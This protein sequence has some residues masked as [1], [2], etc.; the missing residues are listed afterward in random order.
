MAN[1]IQLVEQHFEHT[2]FVG[3]PGYQVDDAH[4][5]LLLVAMDATH[6][7]LKAGRVPRDVVVDHQ[8]AELQIDALAS[9]VGG[10][11]EAGAVGSAKAGH[12][13]F[14]FRP[15]HAAVD[16]GHLIGVAET[17]NAADKEIHGVSVFGEDQPLLSFGAG[18]EGA[19]TVL[20]VL[21]VFQHFAQ[22]LELGF[23]P[24]INQASGTVAQTLQDV[25]FALQF[26][27]GDG[28]DCAKH[29]FLVVL[30]AP[31]RI[32][33]STVQI[34]VVCAMLAVEA[35]LVIQHRPRVQGAGLQFF[36]MPFQLA[37]A[38]LK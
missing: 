10:D 9:G 19:V 33:I 36:D 30:G 35:P 2:A 1:G 37:D 38:P 12:L 7:L 31:L 6:P 28:S 21:G 13:L 34:Q 18:C 24:R 32:V 27:N 23:R 8:V 29:R 15:S 25:D 3:G 16:G 26:L 4:I 20:G 22:L 5:V 11:Q 17:F 14:A